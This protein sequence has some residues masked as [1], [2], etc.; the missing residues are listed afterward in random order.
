MKQEKK[1]TKYLDLPDLLQVSS[2]HVDQ[3]NVVICAA[4]NDL[5][6][7]DDELLEHQRAV[8]SILIDVW[9]S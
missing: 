1:R 4:E 2:I 8:D 9:T 3:Y 5:P 6:I 7:L